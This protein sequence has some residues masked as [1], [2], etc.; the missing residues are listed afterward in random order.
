MGVDIL[1]LPS[2]PTGPA[3]RLK[4]GYC[5]GLGGDR[6]YHSSASYYNKQVSTLN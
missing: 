1:R 4:G 5:L 2:A 6:K 3:L